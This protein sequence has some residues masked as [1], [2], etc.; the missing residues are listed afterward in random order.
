[1]QVV[2]LVEHS[3]LGRTQKSQNGEYERQK[4][5]LSPASI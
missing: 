5:N 1:M 4:E 2:G 3:V